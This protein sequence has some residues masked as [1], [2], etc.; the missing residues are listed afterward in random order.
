MN[1]LVSIIIP[2]YNSYPFVKKTIQSVFE[3]EV[4]DFEIILVNDGST[5]ES[6]SYLSTVKD[7]RFTLINKPNT[8]VSDSRNVGI[9]R[10]K[11]KYVLFLD[12]DDVLS[13]DFLSKRVSILESKPEIGF[14][15]GNIIWIDEKD[16]LIP[17]P[18][19]QIGIAEHILED[20][21][22]F[23]PISSTCPSAYLFRFNTIKE[24]HVRY[25]TKISSPADR[26][27]L[28]QIAPY[29][30]G[31]FISDGGELYY[32]INKNSMSHHLSE[33]LIFDQEN[34]F[35]AV[36]ENKLLPKKIEK[37]FKR[38][39]RYQMFAAFYRLKK[40]RLS[41]LYLLKLT[42]ANLSF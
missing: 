23:N 37:V 28:L 27:F 36:L 35:Y 13:K 20:V 2:C 25:N 31:Y 39:M 9:E 24:H 6:Y 38:K 3:Q 7:D 21:S 30:K 16:Q 12:A 8:G 29:L 15:T 5:D 22:F 4:K 14:C 41:F 18:K 26:Y 1:P 19:R 10:A 34:Y 33:K 17:M 42:K 11:G 32:R 40:Y